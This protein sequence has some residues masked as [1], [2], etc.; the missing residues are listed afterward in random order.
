VTFYDGSASLGTAALDGAGSTSFTAT[1]IQHGTRSITAVYPGDVN[2]T[3]STSNAILLTVSQASSSVA[4]SLTTGAN[5]SQLGQALTFTAT[6]SPE[7]AG[8]PTGQVTFRDGN[9]VI[10]MQS[11]DGSGKAVMT[12]AS[13]G[14]GAHSI[15]AFYA[16]DQNFTGS[17]SSASPLS[18]TVNAAAGTALT[19]LVLTTTPAAI[20]PTMPL[21]RKTMTL[22]ATTTPSTA[23]GTMSFIDGTT[24]LGTATLSSGVASITT[25]LGLG[26]RNITLSYSGDSSFS[27]AIANSV[28]YHSPRP[29]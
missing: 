28:L 3:G 11:L 29:H 4:V 10:G 8:V 17:D 15:T 14:V 26:A 24:L 2:F 9:N 5:P 13:L 1:A 19:S 7:F 16:G 23:T 12:I 20:S 18:Q 22:T 21:F 25:Q 27:P 6:A